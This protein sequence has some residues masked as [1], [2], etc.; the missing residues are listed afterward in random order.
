MLQAGFYLG[1][2]SP[3]LARLNSNES[4][5]HLTQD[6]VSWIG[7]T[8][9]TGGI[10]GAILG[11]VLVEFIGPKNMGLVA[12]AF[13]CVS[14]V[15]IW[16]SDSFLWI[17]IG[18]FL[19]GSMMNMA[20][21]CVAMYLGEVSGAK[22]RGT[23][24]SIAVTGNS[25]GR[26]IGT[27][28]ETYL[29]KHLAC[30]F[31][32]L[33][34]VL[35]VLLLM[36]LLD[37]PYYLIKMNDI[38]GARRSIKLYF[39]NCVLEDKLRDIRNFVEDES[40]LTLKDKLKVFKSR[41]VLR[42]LL[43]IILLYSLA[44]TTGVMNLILYL[45]IIFKRAHS[46]LIEPKQFVIFTNFLSLASRFLTFNVFDVFGRRVVLIAASIMS[47]LTLGCLGLHFFLIHLE[48]NTDSIQWLPIVCIVLFKITYTIG[49]YTGLSAVL[50]EIFPPNV[51]GVAACLAHLF[52][53]LV[54]TGVTYA[55]LPAFNSLG[56]YNVF[57][58][59]AA[60]SFLIT[61]LVLF[62]LP[63]TKGKALEEVHQ[64]QRRS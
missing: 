35:G 40:K 45:E 54:N 6:E 16:L 4:S 1:W 50:S 34:C 21:I 30:P 48:F 52:S 64:S 43:F 61:P 49:F 63:E 33:Q 58:I 23:L 18:R 60:F 22:R 12:F 28:I 62:F 59:H 32:I 11:P 24:I 39:P 2:A 56:E 42:S 31:Y 41:T 57:W 46:T 19:G 10:A 20:F 29:S 9:G 51:K 26:L 25:I 5:N 17:L 38:Q 3:N 44:Q 8:S 47:T 55:F 15:C 37:S 7:S 13:S 36:W 14:W 27:T 53:A